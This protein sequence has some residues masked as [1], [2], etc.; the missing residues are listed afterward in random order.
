MAEDIRRGYVVTSGKFNVPAR[1]FAEEK[2][3]TLLP[4]DIF[5][6]K[7]NALPDAARAEILQ[8]V[9][10]GDYTTPACPKCEAKMGRGD[11]PGVWRCTAHPEQR[12]LS[13]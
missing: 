1:D 5:V 6:E 7:L 12:I 4:G 11:E 13:R 3:I 2:H 9:A 8:Q 10:V